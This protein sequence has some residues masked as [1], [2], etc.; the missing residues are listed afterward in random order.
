MSA[1]GGMDR[2][3]IALPVR[4]RRVS[5]SPKPV[6]GYIRS[7]R[8][9]DWHRDNL[10]NREELPVLIGNRQ[11][12]LRA[13]AWFCVILLAYLSLIPGDFEVRTGAPTRL[14]H[15][16]AYFGTTVFFMLAY[17]RKRIFAVVSLMVYA[18]LLELGQLIS[19]GRFAS[20]V[21]ATASMLGVGAAGALSILI[22]AS[23]LVSGPSFPGER[24]DLTKRML[25]KQGD[26]S[27]WRK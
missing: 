8:I 9:Q 11:R 5:V 15:F 26:H 10:P 23:V 25:E 27:H 3:P 13:C 2:R 21:D 24:H 1:Q 4:P 19:P 18:C 17:P 7:G 6:P 12:N 22:S 16:V 14:E 20:I